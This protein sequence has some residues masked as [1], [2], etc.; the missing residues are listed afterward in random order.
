VNIGYFN[1]RRVPLVCSYKPGYNSRTM[2]V[3]S[4][5]RLVVEGMPNDHE[6]RKQAPAGR[7]GFR[8]VLNPINQMLEKSRHQ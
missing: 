7:T 8:A 1:H 3:V 6:L 4:G 2:N 5:P